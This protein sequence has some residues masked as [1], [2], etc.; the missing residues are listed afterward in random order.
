MHLCKAFTLISLHFHTNTYNNFSSLL[1]SLFIFFLSPFLALS[2]FLLNEVSTLCI[3]LQ[4]E[5]SLSKMSW[6]ILSFYLSIYVPIH[7]CFE[8]REAGTKQ[9]QLLIVDAMVTARAVALN[10]T[11]KPGRVEQLKLTNVI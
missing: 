9:R 2:F 5:F 10:L 4:T 1:S 6:K 8:F 3:I 11:V 7:P